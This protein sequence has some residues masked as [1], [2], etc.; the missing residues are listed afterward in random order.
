VP[1]RAGDL[2]V[3]FV[4]VKMPA[5]TDWVVPGGL[6][7]RGRLVDTAGTPFDSLAADSGVTAPAAGV[8]PEVSIETTV[9]SSRAVWW[10]IAL[11]SQ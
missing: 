7:E 3:R 10:S 2:V 9:S 6:L 11:P 4:A 8:A 1:T 5:P